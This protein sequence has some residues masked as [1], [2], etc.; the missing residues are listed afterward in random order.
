MQ[1]EDRKP[2]ALNR[3]HEPRVLSMAEERAGQPS[4]VGLP[5]KVDLRVY[6]ITGSEQKSRQSPIL[7]KHEIALIS[8][9]VCNVDR[10]VG[11]LLSCSSEAEP[12]M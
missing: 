12:N 5:T 9:D 2:K 11:W 8:Y 6:Q 3:F 10:Y 7:K 1:P 4:L